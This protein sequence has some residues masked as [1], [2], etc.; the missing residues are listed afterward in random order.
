VT[1]VVADASVLAKWFLPDETLREQAMQLL[2]RYTLGELRL[3]V[4]DLFWPEF[5]NILWKAVRQGRCSQQSANTAVS[6]IRER[7]LPTI[8][9]RD[10]IADAFAIA[11]KFNRTVYDGL[12]VA[13]AMALNTQLVTAD[14]R[15][16]NALAA[17]L[18]VKWLGSI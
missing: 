17:Y 15:L 14:E 3:I 16:A 5:G 10:L 4:P 12:Y 9:S 7:N 1:T 6:S 11:S 13:L 8:S 18:P 2:S